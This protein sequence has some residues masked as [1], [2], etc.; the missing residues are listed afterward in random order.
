MHAY[1][2]T[3]VG[4][5]A[6]ALSQAQSFRRCGLVL[7]LVSSWERE[8]YANNKTNVRLRNLRTTTPQNIRCSL[9]SL[10]WARIWLTPMR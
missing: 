9:L 4:T 8:A 3:K 10:R 2:H 5:L 1:I 6:I 7:A